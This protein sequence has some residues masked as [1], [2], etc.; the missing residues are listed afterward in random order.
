MPSGLNATLTTTSVCPV[1]GWPMGWPV[2]ASHNRTVL[3]TPPEAIRLPSGLNATL[4]T[5]AGVSMILSA[6]PSSTTA[7]NSGPSSAWMRR[8]SSRRASVK[9]PHIAAPLDAGQHRLAFRRQPQA[10]C[11]A[12]TRV[13]PVSLVTRLVSLI[14]RD[15]T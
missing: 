7:V 14:P 13:G 12:E 9:R 4:S 5:A 2:S 15:D 10:G 1:I 11:L 6:C 3:S 8:R